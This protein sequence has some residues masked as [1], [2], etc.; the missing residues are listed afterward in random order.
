DNFSALYTR[1]YCLTANLT[2]ITCCVSNHS[3]SPT[4]AA[5][6]INESSCSSSAARTSAASKGAQ[7]SA[8]GPAF[9]CSISSSVTPQPRAIITCC[10]H[11]YSE[12]QSQ[13]VRKISSSRSRAGSVLL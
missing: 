1:C 6:L 7:P 5:L 10:P 9:K 12:R 8:S 11:S 2:Y 13:P 3:A 4:H